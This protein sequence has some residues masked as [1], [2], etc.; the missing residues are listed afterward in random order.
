MV[1]GGVALLAIVIVLI[2]AAVKH[3]KKRGRN[4]EPVQTE[5]TPPYGYLPP[6]YHSD[7]PPSYQA[8][9][10]GDTGMPHEPRK[11]PL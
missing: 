7:P 11:V 1:I 3:C 2:V 10:D 5:M 6:M 8:T 9:S 4:V